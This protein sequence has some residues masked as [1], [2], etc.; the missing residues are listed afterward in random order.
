MARFSLPFHLRCRCGAL[1][2]CGGK[3]RLQLR[4]PPDHSDQVYHC[5][6]RREGGE[7]KLR[8]DIREEALQ[9]RDGIRAIVPGDLA[10]SDVVARIH[11]QRSRRS[12][13]AAEE[14]HP[15]TPREV[16]LIK[17]WIAQGRSTRSIGRLQTGAAAGNPSL[18]RV[19]PRKRRLARERLEPQSIDAFILNSFH[20]R[21]RESPAADPQTSVAASTSITGIPPTPKTRAHSFDRSASLG[22]AISALIDRLLVCSGVRERWAKM[23]LDLARYADSTVRFDKFG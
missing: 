2:E 1:R 23:W 20:A 7:A 18:R 12:D 19:T 15:L 6:G 17:R 22:S 4:H 9:E 5:P 21:A 16:E 14:A 11:F 3:G 13:A 8:L 10:A